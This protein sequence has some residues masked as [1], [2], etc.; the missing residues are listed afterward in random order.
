MDHRVV[1]M[2]GPDG[3]PGFAIV[4]AG[5]PDDP[6]K[7]WRSLSTRAA[8]KRGDGQLQE[9]DLGKHGTSVNTYP[10]TQVGKDGTAGVIAPSSPTHRPVCVA[11]ST[12]AYRHGEG[13]PLRS[14]AMRRRPH[15][16]WV[17]VFVPAGPV[18]KSPP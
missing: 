10:P 4:E 2:P 9:S 16:T 5:A 7:L 15:G 14:G 1:E 13:E 3:S 18:C 8:S 11:G 6:A 17:A 12:P